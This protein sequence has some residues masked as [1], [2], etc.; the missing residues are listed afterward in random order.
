MFL[1]RGKV[2][3]GNTQYSASAQH[4]RIASSIRQVRAVPSFKTNVPPSIL[5]HYSA[6]RVRPVVG[7]GQ[8]QP[9][10]GEA[11]LQSPEHL[12]VPD[13]PSK[14]VFLAARKSRGRTRGPPTLPKSTIGTACQVVVPAYQQNRPLFAI[15]RSLYQIPIKLGSGSNWVQTN[16]FPELPKSISSHS[17]HTVGDATKSC[18]CHL[19]HISGAK[20]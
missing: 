12:H 20:N 13:S 9:A 16:C 6:T 15:D 4:H 2:K 3:N 5:C 11:P 8:S 10:A 18:Y 19:R 17:P 1:G 14:T 7:S